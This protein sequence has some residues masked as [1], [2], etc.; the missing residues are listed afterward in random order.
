MNR[1]NVDPR[2]WGPPAW[3]FLNAVVSSYP[4]KAL[5]H[6]QLWMADFLTVLGDALP[7]EVC[8]F[9]Y[10]SYLRQ[11]PVRDFVDGRDGVATY[12]REYQQMSKMGKHRPFAGW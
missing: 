4:V 5:P 6:E 7:C 9:D 3:S 2:V 12:L 11:R 10:K 8:R 1:N